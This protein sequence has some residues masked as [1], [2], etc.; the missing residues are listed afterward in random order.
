M[1]EKTIFNA[2]ECNNFSNVSVYLRLFYF[3]LRLSLRRFFAKLNMIIA[4]L[5]IET[6]SIRSTPY[7]SQ[8]NAGCSLLITPVCRYK[9]A[10]H[11]MWGIWI[12]CMIAIMIML[13][14]ILSSYHFQNLDHICINYITYY[15]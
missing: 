10:F 5:I 14:S 6:I 9:S 4:T 12:N 13:P 1:F 11:T 3:L 8:S 7:K 15:I 2:K